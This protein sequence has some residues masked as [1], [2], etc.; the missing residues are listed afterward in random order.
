MIMQSNIHDSL[1]GKWVIT[2]PYFDKLIQFCTIV[3]CEFMYID[4]IRSNERRALGVRS[5]D[6]PFMPAKQEF[7]N[8]VRIMG[9]HSCHLET[10]LKINQSIEV[11]LL[12]NIKFLEVMNEDFK[13]YLSSKESEKSRYNGENGDSIFLGLIREL[14]QSS[15]D[16]N[17]ENRLDAFKRELH[18]IVENESRGMEIAD[19]KKLFYQQYK[20]FKHFR[21]SALRVQSSSGCQANYKFKKGAL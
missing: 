18:L 12:E 13:K 9:T 4:V 14:E 5:E 10:F 17:L 11:V 1:F 7:Q 6:C 8:A 16:S 3:D 20:E 21:L 2:S 19:A 15:A